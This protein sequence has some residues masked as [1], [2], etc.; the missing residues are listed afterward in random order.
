MKTNISHKDKCKKLPTSVD[1]NTC[2][3]YI[4]GN[5]WDPLKLKDFIVLCKVFI[6]HCHL[7]NYK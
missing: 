6:L 1:A 5:I 7:F 4:I 3:L 2:T